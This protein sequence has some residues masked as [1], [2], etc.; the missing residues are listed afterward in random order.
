M[1]RQ[2]SKTSS[3]D[4]QSSPK[5][6]RPSPNANFFETKKSNDDRKKI[7][8]VSP[9][10]LQ[11]PEAQQWQ[12][13]VESK[14][15]N[16]PLPT[17][18][19]L[20]PLGSGTFGNVTLVQI[21]SKAFVVKTI[22][23]ESDDESE[24]ATIANEVFILEH[25]RP[26]CSEQGFLCF[27]DHFAMK[28]P[29]VAKMQIQDYIITEALVDYVTLDDVLPSKRSFL[30]PLICSL[31]VGLLS[32]H[33]NGIVHHDIK[34][35]NILIHK[36]DDVFDT[37]IKYI[38]FGLSCADTSKLTLTE[39][40]DSKYVSK[41]CDAYSEA[42]SP[43]YVAPEISVKRDDVK[44]D[45]DTYKKGDIWSLGATIFELITGSRLHFFIASQAKRRSLVDLPS[46]SD[47]TTVAAAATVDDV[48]VLVESD[49]DATESDEEEADDD[50]EWWAIEDENEQDEWF[51]AYMTQYP[52]DYDPIMRKLL[53]EILFRNADLLS[54]IAIDPQK[55]TISQNLQR[56]CRDTVAILAKRKQIQ[57][58]TPII[59]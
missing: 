5:R 32:M 58:Q 15:Y 29:T 56:A 35:E 46:S 3:V 13:I 23:H 8:V 27:V 37:Q 17:G 33:D 14:F 24:I 44:Y 1:K 6:A 11:T 57:T 53:L 10:R 18:V 45:L 48:K 59:V 43:D 50:T 19:I 36:S 51:N 52:N 21:G 22:T 40:D 7:V 42:G 30:M 49:P 26:H 28:V 16:R 39:E 34:P 54:M 55:R 25:L 47:E 9:P 31:I 20:R 41:D 2:L 4:E 12:K 38:D